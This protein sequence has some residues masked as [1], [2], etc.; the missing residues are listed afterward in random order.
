M[1]KMNNMLKIFTLNKLRNIA[2]VNILRIIYNSPPK[3]HAFLSLPLKSKFALKSFFKNIS[4]AAF[5]STVLSVSIISLIK[6]CLINMGIE[7]DSIPQNFYDFFTTSFSIVLLKKVFSG[8]VSDLL[9]DFKI[10]NFNVTDIYKQKMC[11]HGEQD[12]SI[13]KYRRPEAESNNNAGPSNSNPNP[14]A[15]G[16]RSVPSNASTSR[17]YETGT[18]STTGARIDYEL[19]APGIPG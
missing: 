3:A 4:L 1:N 7:V 19:G 8:A 6:H 9:E 17:N 13:V 2:I 10:K 15:S 18:P 14:A 16:A 5:I 12:I 11:S